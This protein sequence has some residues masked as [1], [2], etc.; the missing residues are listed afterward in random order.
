MPPVWCITNPLSCP[1]QRGV[2][3]VSMGLAAWDGPSMALPT[4]GP[5]SCPS[6]LGQ[7]VWNCLRTGSRL[8][9][10]FLLCKA[11]ANIQLKSTEAF[12]CWIS[13]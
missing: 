3:G 13:P 1:C 6:G 2:R 9:I 4:S 12:S 7:A 8:Y 5:F 11:G 10:S